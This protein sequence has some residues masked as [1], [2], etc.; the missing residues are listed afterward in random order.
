MSTKS[1]DSAVESS[2][3][4][5]IPPIATR[6]DMDQ[7]A[8]ELYKGRELPKRPGLSVPSKI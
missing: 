4:S 7:K 5:P 2:N 3:Q 8:D 1:V 6:S